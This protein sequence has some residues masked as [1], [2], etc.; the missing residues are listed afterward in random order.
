MEAGENPP[1]VLG[2][3]VPKKNGG[4]R[5]KGSGSNFRL[6]SKLKAGDPMS[7]IWGV[8]LKKLNS[9]RN[10]GYK[11]GMN[12]KARLIDQDGYAVWRA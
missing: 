12:L 7:C 9:L 2:V 5:P 3:P 1:I 6:L 11:L 10:T 4:G 8:S